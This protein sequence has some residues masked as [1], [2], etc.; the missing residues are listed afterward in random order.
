MHTAITDLE[1]AQI[2]SDIPEKGVRDSPTSVPDGRR[3][4]ASK[5]G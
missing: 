5:V 1:Q 4:N 3:V 2:R